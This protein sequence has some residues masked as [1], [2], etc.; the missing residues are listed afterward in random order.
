MQES[1]LQRGKGLGVFDAHHRID[2][3]AQHFL[4]AATCRD[5]TCAEFHKSDVGFCRG[6]HARTMHGDLATASQCESCRRDHDRFWRITHA[7]VQIL[8]FADCSIEHIPH[9][10]LRADHHHKQV[11][12]SAEILS[13][14][15]DH[16]SIKISLEPIE[17]FHRHVHDIFIEG[18][19]LRVEFK[20]SDTIADIADGRT[21]VLRHDLFLL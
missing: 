12:A 1:T 11:C 20:T 10:L 18:V 13:F 3:P 8:Q 21:H 19:H 16:K 15:A 7:H 9:T 4:R 5:N 2:N 17:R 6:D 14:V